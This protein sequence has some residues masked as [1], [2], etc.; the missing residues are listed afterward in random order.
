MP[1]ARVGARVTLF[2]VGSGLSQE[3]VASAAGFAQYTF[4]KFEK[5]ESKP[6]T[7]ANPS[8]LNVL[9]IAQALDTSIEDLLPNGGPNPL[10]GRH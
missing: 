1:S 7:A 6:G 5:G 3:D 8:L 9:A 10:Q 2:V 4:Q